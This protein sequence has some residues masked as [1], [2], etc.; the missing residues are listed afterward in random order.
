MRN[1]N[2]EF[3]NSM[4]TSYLC[5]IKGYTQFMKNKPSQSETHKFIRRQD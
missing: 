4:C 1:K 5:I 2:A 3:L